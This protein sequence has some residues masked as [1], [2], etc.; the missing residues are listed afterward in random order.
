MS[1]CWIETIPVERAAGELREIYDEVKSPHG[2]VDNVYLAQSLR[3]HTLRAHDLLYRSVLHDRDN[4][5]PTWF[6]EVVSVY[7]SLLN[8]CQ[9]AVTHHFANVRRL[10]QDEARS[11]KV[12]EALRRTRPQEA[13]AGKELAL[14]QYTEKLTRDPAS[15][16]R[17]DIEC[18]RKSG[19]DVGEDTI[20]FYPPG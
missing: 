5:L 16:R 7:T 9:Y 17:A 14:L 13:F 19:A 1:V 12:F 10:L 3:P 18:L 8:R 20:G 4:T 6:L 15:V 11:V 2:T